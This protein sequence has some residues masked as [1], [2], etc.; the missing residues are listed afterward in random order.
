[1]VYSKSGYAEKWCVF[2]TNNE[3]WSF[4]WVMTKYA[5]QKFEIQFV[6]FIQNE[7]V[8]MIDIDLIDG[9]VDS[10]YCNIQYTFTAINDEIINNMN[11]ENTTDHFNTHMKLWEDS[12]NYFLKTGKMLLN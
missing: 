10:V 12:L 2:Q 1:M 5:I 6:K 9:E 7:M 3:F 4:Q 8:V 11:E